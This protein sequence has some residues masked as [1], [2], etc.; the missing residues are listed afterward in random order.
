M[1]SVSCPTVPSR[2]CP[3]DLRVDQSPVNN[4]RTGQ[5]SRHCPMPGSHYPLWAHLIWHSSLSQ[6]QK[7]QGQLIWSPTAGLKGTE[8]SAHV[9]LYKYVYKSM[10]IVIV[11]GLLGS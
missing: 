4:L 1:D 9:T 8:V 10:Y 11:R 2:K 5:I 3:Q 6:E 7:L